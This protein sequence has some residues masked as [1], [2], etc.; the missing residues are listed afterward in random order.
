M[1]THAHAKRVAAVAGLMACA[2]VP[3]LAACNTTDYNRSRAESA[4]AQ[5]QQRADRARDA[6]ERQQMQPYHQK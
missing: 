5:Q 3:A 1:R 2:C 4:A 6:Y